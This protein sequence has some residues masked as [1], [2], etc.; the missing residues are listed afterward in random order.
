MTYVTINY[1]ALKNYIQD[2]KDKYNLVDILYLLNYG[3]INQQQYED[4]VTIISKPMY[5]YKSFLQE[6]KGY[7]HQQ[8]PLTNQQA[9]YD[10][11]ANNKRLLHRMVK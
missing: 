7:Y 9:R 10:I 1:S 4:L 2:Q 11:I 8:G 5:D 6:D 3:Y